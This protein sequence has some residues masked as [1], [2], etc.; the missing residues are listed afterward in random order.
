M[1][2]IQIFFVIFLGMYFQL[3]AAEDLADSEIVPIE[4]LLK[5]DFDAIAPGDLV[6]FDVDDVL[7]EPEDVDCVNVDSIYV[8]ELAFSLF[9]E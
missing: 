7:I 2:Y 1:K 6:A 3:S 9:E 8:D 5:I 4:S